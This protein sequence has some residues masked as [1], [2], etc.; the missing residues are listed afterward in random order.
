[1][2][3]DPA[4]HPVMRGQSSPRRDGR[5]EFRWRPSLTQPDS[6]YRTLFRPARYNRYHGL[7]PQ[8]VAEAISA[9]MTENSVGQRRTQILESTANA[10]Y[11]RSAAQDASGVERRPR[12]MGVRGRL[13]QAARVQSP[14]TPSSAGVPWANAISPTDRIA[15]PAMR[16]TGPAPPR[17]R[18]R[19]HARRGHLHSTHT[20]DSF[21]AYSPHTGA[22][23]DHRRD[24]TPDAAERVPTPSDVR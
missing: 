20:A 14:R 2:G 19:A 13:G 3:I 17:S 1:M 4:G 11:F 24:P 7:D 9:V 21:S 12:K 15:G 8:S 22:T 23:L 18:A 5:T 10:A 6:L 16:E